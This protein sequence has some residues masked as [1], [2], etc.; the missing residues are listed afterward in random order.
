MYGPL[1]VGEDFLVGK[2]TSQWQYIDMTYLN[3]RADV[4][5]TIVSECSKFTFKTLE[6]QC[7]RT[8]MIISFFLRWFMLEGQWSDFCH[9]K[10]VPIMIKTLSV[11]SNSLSV[12]SKSFTTQQSRL[13]NYISIALKYFHLCVQR[14]PRAVFYYNTNMLFFPCGSM[15]AFQHQIQI[16]EQTMTIFQRNLAKNMVT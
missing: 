15:L 4:I 5:H 2:L 16:L 7:I 9:A 13:Y 1:E 3:V 11:F 10:L 6:V 8:Y 14:C 12:D